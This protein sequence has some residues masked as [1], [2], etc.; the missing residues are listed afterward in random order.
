MGDQAISR[1]KFAKG[2]AAAGLVTTAGSTIVWVVA[3]DG[4]PRPT[5]FAVEHGPDVYVWMGT[6]ESAAVRI[7]QIDGTVLETFHAGTAEAL[8]KIESTHVTFRKIAIPTAA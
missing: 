5:A 2:V 7:H 8:T 4:D 6:G 3:G 1:R